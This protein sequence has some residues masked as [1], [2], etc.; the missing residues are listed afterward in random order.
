MV[1][2]PTNHGVV[3]YGYD[4]KD[5]LQMRHW[6]ND[7][8]QAQLYAE[9]YIHVPLNAWV[10]L[11]PLVPQP[12]TP[13]KWEPWAQGVCKILRM[14]FRGRKIHA[15][16]EHRK[17][18]QVALI[19]S[20]KMIEAVQAAY[21]QGLPLDYVDLLVCEEVIKY[22][23]AGAWELAEDSYSR[24]STL[25]GNTLQEHLNRINAAFKQGTP[26]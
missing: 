9:D 11:P 21:K 26:P 18:V 1:L 19:E 16:H 20:K 7:V 24:L 25:H 22:L 6:F 12:A 3:M 14:L 17:H 2:Q 8:L 13:N 5:N 4:T 23:H 15:I 10:A